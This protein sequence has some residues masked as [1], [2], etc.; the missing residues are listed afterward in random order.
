MSLGSGP[1]LSNWFQ[2]GITR[3]SALTVALAANGAVFALPSPGP[4][5]SKGQDGDPKNHIHVLYLV[6]VIYEGGNMQAGFLGRA[7]IIREGESE[8]DC[9]S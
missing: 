1:T 2:A 7:N 9:E 6:N 8:E 4:M 3:Q 5:L